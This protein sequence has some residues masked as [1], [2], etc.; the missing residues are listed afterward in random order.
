M[1][2]SDQDIERLRL[3]AESDPDAKNILHMYEQLRAVGVGVQDENDRRWRV[4]VEAEGKMAESEK[5]KTMGAHRDLLERFGFRLSVPV[6]K[7]KEGEAGHFGDFY[8][9]YCSGGMVL[10]DEYEMK[11]APTPKPRCDECKK[12]STLRCKQCHEHYC[13]RACQIKAWPLHKPVC[14]AIA[15]ERL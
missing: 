4:M 1:A 2:L 11:S 12:L 8:E 10:K 5:P 9:K 7:E 3:V 15:A 13:S 14:V 6:P